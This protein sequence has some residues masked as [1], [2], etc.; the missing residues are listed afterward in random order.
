[1]ML[2]TLFA[3][4]QPLPRFEAMFLRKDFGSFRKT[5]VVPCAV[6]RTRWIVWPGREEVVEV[7]RR[8]VRDVVEGESGVEGRYVGVGWGC[9]LGVRE[10]GIIERR[11]VNIVAC[12]VVGIGGDG[13]R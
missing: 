8:G 9:Q 12:L 11:F 3:S 4:P 2:V 7:R 5:E 6:P 10:G 13:L 1:M